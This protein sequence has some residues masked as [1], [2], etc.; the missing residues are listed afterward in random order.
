MDRS[1]F[2]WLSLIVLIVC[3]CGFTSSNTMQ[4]F[5]IFPDSVFKYHNK[6]FILDDSLNV[7]YDKKST[8]FKLHKLSTTDRQLLTDPLLGS[9][10]LYG[11]Y[12]YSKQNRT[13]KITPILILV[14]ADDYQSVVLFAVSDEKKVVSHLELTTDACDVL[15]Q[16]EKKE[17]VGC[18]Q[19]DS[20]FLNDSTIRVTDLKILLDDYD[21]KDQVTT[22]D[23]LSILY[24]ISSAGKIVQVQKDSVRYI[25]GKP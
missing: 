4:G 24:R 16:T 20:E 12:F 7:D 6:R 11:A 8:N 22:T 1:R 15:E 19:R 17:I 2:L 18:H 25:K 9:T 10:S 3:G 21:K 14:N 23:S 5:N 13:K